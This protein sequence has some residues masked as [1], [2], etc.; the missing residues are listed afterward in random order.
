MNYLK[1]PF[2]ILEMYEN[3]EIIGTAADK[4]INIVND[5]DLQEYINLEGDKRQ[6]YINIYEEFKKKFKD[7]IMNKDIFITDFKCGHYKSIPIRWNYENMMNGY[8][9][10]EDKKIWFINALQQKSVIKLDVLFLDSETSRLH[11]ISQNYYIEINNNSNYDKIVKKNIKTSLLRSF[12][13]YYYNDKNFFKAMKRLYSYY[14]IFDE[15]SKKI[16]LFQD[17]FNS[18]MGKQNKIISDLKTL[19]LLMEQTFRPVKKNIILD[20]LLALNFSSFD[21]N[22]KAMYDTL[23]NNFKRMSKN[24]VKEHIENIINNVFNELNDKVFKY[25]TEKKLLNNII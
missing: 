4:D 7:A 11:E 1:K 21:E 16:K 8:K 22:I 13:D 17:L 15:R 3:Q 6:L 19:L 25:I 12:K 9:V 20:N 23:I 18:E 5:Y 24:Q 14:K 10:I 2:N